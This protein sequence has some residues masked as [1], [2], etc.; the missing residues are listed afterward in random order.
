MTYLCCAINRKIPIRKN[1]AFHFNYST[2]Q[3]KFY[4]IFT[5][6]NENVILN[7]NQRDVLR[8]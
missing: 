4:I 7:E 8:F 6:E 5:I 1:E 3:D 2:E